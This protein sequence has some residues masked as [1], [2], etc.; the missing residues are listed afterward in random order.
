MKLSNYIIIVYILFY[1]ILSAFYADTYLEIMPCKKIPWDNSSPKH[2][3]KRNANNV[4]YIF[5]GKIKRNFV[6]K[7]ISAG[8]RMVA[9]AINDKYDEW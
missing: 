8:N 3:I 1:I 2:D 9:S 4:G 5:T 7:K 6:H